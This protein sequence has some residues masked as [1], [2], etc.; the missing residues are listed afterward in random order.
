MWTGLWAQST[1]YGALVTLYPWFKQP[2]DWKK[3]TSTRENDIAQISTLESTLPDEL[4][5]F[6]FLYLKSIDIIYSF[7]N[8]NS[9]FDRL[10]SPFLCAIDLSAIDEHILDGYCQRILPKIRHHVKTIKFDDKNIYRILPLS[11]AYPNLCSLSITEIPQ[12]NGKYLPYLESFKEVCSLKMYFDNEPCEQ[13]LSNE[14]FSN[15]FQPNCQLQ[16]LMIHDIYFTI[17]AG[18]IR[19]CSI[20]TLKIMLRSQFDLN[21]LLKNLPSIEFL[22]V[23]LRRVI[24]QQ[25][26]QQT[27]DNIVSLPKLK[28]FMFFSVF[29]IDYNSL[30]RLL[31][32]C[33]NLEYLSL[34][35]DS[36]QFI[37]GY[38][39]EAKL[40]SKLR[41]LTKFHFCLRI[42]NVTMI[43]ISDYIET[44]KSSYWLNH[45]VLCFKIAYRSSHY[46]IFSLPYPFSYLI[47]TSNDIVNYRSN[48]SNISM[49]NRQSRVKEISLYDTVPFTLELFKF[50]E[51]TFVKTTVLQLYSLPVNILNDDLMNDTAFILENILSLM[52]QMEKMVDFK[53]LKRL[54]LMM[55][56]IV[57]LYMH[58]NLLVDLKTEDF[59]QQL[60]PLLNRIK[61]VYI[62]DSPVEILEDKSLF[63]N[64]K[65]MRNKL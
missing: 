54:L 24:R 49:Y 42:P 55:P 5:E 47:F 44:Y 41:K 34:N 52:F 39:L 57:E 2:P 40:L 56:N 59:G 60:Q 14:I 53:Y 23:Q 22:D 63:P 58:W 18:N 8:L 7:F 43:N 51:E 37:D 50:I 3:L 11:T 48:I 16:T 35:L 33:P 32:R 1:P 65:I 30:E 26:H 9:R 20:K 10:I 4:Y 62:A 12:V 61:K 27:Y 45:P 15:L 13:K 28:D 17:H 29:P 64:A 25:N 36:S 6:I 38:S 21:V 46:C 19:S 31:S